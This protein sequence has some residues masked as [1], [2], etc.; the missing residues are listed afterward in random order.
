ML[1]IWSLFVSCILYLGFPMFQISSGRGRAGS[2]EKETVLP[3]S[4]IA[5]SLQVPFFATPSSDKR[6]ATCDLF[7]KLQI[8]SCGPEGAPGEGAPR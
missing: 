8:N 6:P 5:D 7:L 1:V 4:G 2:F 3:T